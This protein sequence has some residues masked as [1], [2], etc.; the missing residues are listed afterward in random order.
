[1]QEESFEKDF[2]NPKTSDKALKKDIYKE[3][4]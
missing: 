3:K 4:I 2:K 1:M